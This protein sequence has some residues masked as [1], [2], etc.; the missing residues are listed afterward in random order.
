MNFADHQAI[1]FPL[2]YIFESFLMFYYSTNGSCVFLSVAGKYLLQIL[3]MFLEV[4]K[5]KRDRRNGDSVNVCQQNEH[6]TI[7]DNAHILHTVVVIF[8]SV[9]R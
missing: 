5:L 4:V 7:L 1:C 8:W 3:N 2:L 6:A 9:C